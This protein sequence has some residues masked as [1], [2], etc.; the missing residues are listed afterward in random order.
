MTPSREQA[1]M[2]TE[3]QAYQQRELP[4]PVWPPYDPVVPFRDYPAD[5]PY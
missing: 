5:V 3:L 1:Q 4:A 2:Q